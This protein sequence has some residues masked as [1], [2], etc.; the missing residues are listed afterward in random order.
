MRSSLNI[1]FEPI[2]IGSQE[3]WRYLFELCANAHCTVADSISVISQIVESECRAIAK[4]HPDQTE[5]I[6]F[7]FHLQPVA[8]TFYF[9]A[10]T[11]GDLWCGA[12]NIIRSEG[13]GRGF[14]GF[15]PYNIS[16]R[17]TS[18]WR[19]RT[20]VT[21]L[22]LA[23]HVA[24]LKTRTGYRMRRYRPTRTVKVNYAKPCVR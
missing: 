13:P 24:L 21:L 15:F 2:F 9:W 3:T 16:Y 17:L 22:Q 5:S 23:R 6:F 1:V 20:V 12:P 7:F 10:R 18:Q 11:V 14:T 19:C 8:E 4:V